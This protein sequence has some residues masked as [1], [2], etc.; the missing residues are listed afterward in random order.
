MGEQELRVKASEL[1]RL[2]IACQ[3]GTEMIFTPVPVHDDAPDFIQCPNCRNR[4]VG[5]WQL[6][7]AYREFAAALALDPDR[8]A[9]LFKLP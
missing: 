5:A 2:V 9:F 3:C 6:V 4:V 8:T 1:T 7:R